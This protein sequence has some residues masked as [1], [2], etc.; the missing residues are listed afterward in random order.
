MVYFS[1]PWRPAEIGL[2]LGR[3]AFL[4]PGKGRGGML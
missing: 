1:L 3:P 2:Q 4:A